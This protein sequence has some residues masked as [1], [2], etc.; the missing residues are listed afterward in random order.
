MLQ[1][2]VEIDIKELALI[3]TL[4]ENNI[5]SIYSQYRQIHPRYLVEPINT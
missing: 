1:D 5:I 2:N 3:F 4:N